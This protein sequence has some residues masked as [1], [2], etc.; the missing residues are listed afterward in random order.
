MEMDNRIPRSCFCALC[1][2]YRNPYGSFQISFL[3]L[4]TRIMLSRRRRTDNH[5]FDISTSQ[6]RD[7]F[8]PS[9]KA[10]IICLSPHSE[11]ILDSFFKYSWT[12]GL[13]IHVMHTSSTDLSFLWSILL[14]AVEEKESPLVSPIPTFSLGAQMRLQGSGK[15][16]TSSDRKSN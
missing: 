13:Q 6:A 8:S 9:V 5:C 2:I 7:C 12:L 16:K 14:C 4:A 1:C 3:F 15:K 10:G 11:L